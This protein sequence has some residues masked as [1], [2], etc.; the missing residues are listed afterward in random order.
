MRIG[1][2]SGTFDPVHNGHLFF[3]ERAQ[4]LLKLD[5][6]L[7]LPEQ[8]P[9]GKTPNA[10]Y[11]H[12]IKMLSIALETPDINAAVF[13]SHSPQFSIKNTLPEIQTQ[14]GD[15]EL[16][17]LCGVDVWNALFQNPWPDIEKLISKVIFV[18]G[19]RANDSA[20]RVHDEAIELEKELHLPSGSLKTRVIVDTMAHIS[21][22]RVRGRYAESASKLDVSES[23]AEYIAAHRL[24]GA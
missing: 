1:I 8:Q 11:E 6:I 7:F 10:S 16:Y 17:M 18:I 24:Y 9:R 13:V 21:S 23:V 20:S 14:T 3:A 19:V 4:K 15:A 12:R 5:N 2:Y 22:T